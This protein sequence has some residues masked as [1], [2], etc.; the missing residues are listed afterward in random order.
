MFGQWIA[1]ISDHLERLFGQL[2]DCM[3]AVSQGS[4]YTEYIYIL[5][6]LYIHR[7]V[8]WSG[9]TTVCNYTVLLCTSNIV[10][11]SQG[12]VPS[13]YGNLSEYTIQIVIDLF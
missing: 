10:V 13:T 7:R 4:M 3:T 6:L 9:G 11:R 2:L 1:G 5:L 12:R 8:V